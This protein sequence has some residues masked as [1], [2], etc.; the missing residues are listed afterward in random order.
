VVFGLSSSSEDAEV[1]RLMEELELG[2]SEALGMSLLEVCAWYFRDSS[3]GEDSKVGRDLVEERNYGNVIV[4]H[5]R[6]GQYRTKDIDGVPYTS[7]RD[8][9]F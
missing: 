4:N 6:S 3:K 1:G 5:I 7:Y 8:D 2:V 9:T